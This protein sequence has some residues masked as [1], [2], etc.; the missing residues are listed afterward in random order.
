MI[1]GNE[2]NGLPRPCAMEVQLCAE[3]CGVVGL[4][5]ATEMPLAE[6]GRNVSV[7]PYDASVLSPDAP[8]SD[9]GIVNVEA[10][11]PDDSVQ[12]GDPTDVGL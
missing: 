8:I 4:S 6:V 2:W 9:G 3:T 7:D 12:Y 11:E 10:P 1:G 5:A